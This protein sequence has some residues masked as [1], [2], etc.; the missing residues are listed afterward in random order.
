M[1]LLSTTNLLFQEFYGSRIPKYAILSHRWYGDEVTFEEFY[2]VK[3]QDPFGQRFAKIRNCCAYAQ[4]NGFGW[5][6]IDTCCIDKKSSAELT[7]AIN[8]M[9]N[10]YSNAGRCYVYLA[11]VWWDAGDLAGSRVDFRKSAWFERGWTLQELLAP[12]VL[13]F[14]D[15]SWKPI[16]TINKYYFEAN[17][18]MDAKRLMK[19]ICAATSIS[20]HDLKYSFDYDYLASEVCVARKMSWLSSRKTSRVED[21]AYCMLGL[22]GVNMPLLYGEGESAF[23]RLQLEIIRTSDDESIFVWFYPAH[24]LL[25]QDSEVL[26]KSPR[27]FAQSGQVIK[28]PS[29]RG[30]LPFA[31]TNKGLHYR[32]PRS[33]DWISPSR[34]GDKYML[35]LDCGLEDSKDTYNSLYIAIELRRDDVSW[36]RHSIYAIALQDKAKWNDIVDEKPEFEDLYLRTR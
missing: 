31:M 13:C 24:T 29:L 28:H 21:I 3:A 6:W 11:D 20:E 26:A 35:L 33:R 27:A 5:V 7:E 14:V 9:F 30:K 8:S 1:R 17:L 15:Y 10:W 25:A 22:C 34:T 12:T 23:V 32:I 4:K 36:C 2:H 16:G 19:D 18:D